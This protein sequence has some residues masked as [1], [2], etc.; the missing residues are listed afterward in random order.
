MAEAVTWTPRPGTEMD[1]DLAARARSGDTTAFESLLEPRMSGLARFALAV[2]GDEH[3]AR[4]AV[5]TACVQA[6]REL[7]ALRD[8]ARFDAWLGRILANS[9]RQLLR[10]RKRRRVREIAVSELEPRADSPDMS[11]MA[12]GPA[13]VVADL[14]ALGRAFDRLDSDARILL[15]HH[16]LEGLSIGDIA[17]RTG[18]SAATVKWRLHM[19]RAALERSL[20]AEYR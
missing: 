12:P 15:V 7:P 3:D 6:W 17:A 19:A 1:L 5:Q 11:G 18:L 9:C 14:D 10:S 13:D 4:D 8:V 16:H 20:E 2:I